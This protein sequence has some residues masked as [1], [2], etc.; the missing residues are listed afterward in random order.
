MGRSKSVRS[1]A[2]SFA[3]STTAIPHPH[4]IPILRRLARDGD[5]HAQYALPTERVRWE[6]RAAAMGDV[7]GLSCRDGEGVTKSL[8]SARKWWRLAAKRG[9]KAAAMALETSRAGR[10]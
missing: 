3:M 9:S 1:G 6:R 7:E 2:R 5:A 4:R 10:A 8:R